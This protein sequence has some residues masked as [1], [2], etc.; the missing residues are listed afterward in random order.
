MINH[1]SAYITIRNPGLL[2]AMQK[3]RK[4]FLSARDMPQLIFV[5]EKIAGMVPD[6]GLIHDGDGDVIFTG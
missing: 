1:G 5:H 2:E 4:W 3:Y 6:S